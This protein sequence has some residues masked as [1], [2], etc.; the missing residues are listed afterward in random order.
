MMK[1]T[2]GW[3]S[4]GKRHPY[5]GNCMGTNFPDFP[6]SMGFSAFFHMLWEMKCMSTNFPVSPDAMSFVAFSRAMGN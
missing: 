2:A 3:E 1:Y 4:N 6:H 5:Y